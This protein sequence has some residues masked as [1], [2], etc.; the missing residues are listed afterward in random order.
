M[1]IKP[2]PPTP[3][4]AGSTT[5]SAAAVAIA[6]S[7]A[8]PPA[9]IVCIP[10]C[11]ARACPDVTIPFLPITDGRNAEAVIPCGDLHLKPPLF[12]QMISDKLLPII[13]GSV[14]VNKCSMFNTQVPSS[15]R[16]TKK[17][18]N[19]VMSSLWVLQVDLQEFYRD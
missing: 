19:L 6:A 9:I 16:L 17:F 2:S 3:D 13:S 5:P 10:A 18:N 14:V 7:T 8:L 4:P 15:D 12:I 1:N 11:E